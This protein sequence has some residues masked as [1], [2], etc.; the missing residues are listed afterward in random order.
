MTV[1][2]IA[3]VAF[4]FVSSIA[5][6]LPSRAAEE[7]VWRA[8]AAKA[9][10]TPKEAIWMAGYA[11]RTSPAN[12]TLHE[13]YVRALALEDNHGHQAVIVSTD[14]DYTAQGSDG[15]QRV[16]TFLPD[17]TCREEGVEIRVEEKGVQPLT[18]RLR[19]ITGSSITTK[20]SSPP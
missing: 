6:P 15:W 20:G 5:T 14:D 12:G 16:A 13:L 7:A 17:G 1:P 19:G 18:I 10:I 11:S 2:R 8:G 4:C 9:V 3:F